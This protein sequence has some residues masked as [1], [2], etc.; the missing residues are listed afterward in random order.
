M[1]KW[2]KTTTILHFAD[3][4]GCFMARFNDILPVVNSKI[5]DKYNIPLN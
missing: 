1:G 3:H 2:H 4:S 5:V